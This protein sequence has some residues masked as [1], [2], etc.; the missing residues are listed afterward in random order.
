MIRAA[1]SAKKRDDNFFLLS[2]LFIWFFVFTYFFFVDFL[3]MKKKNFFLFVC[4]F[5]SFCRLILDFLFVCYII[6]ERTLMFFF[7]DSY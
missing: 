6:P 3:K 7:S 1:Q 4:L 2:Y 5:L